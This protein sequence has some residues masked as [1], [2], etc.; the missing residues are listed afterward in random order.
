MQHTTRRWRRQLG[1]A[2]DAGLANEVCMRREGGLLQAQVPRRLVAKGRGHNVPFGKD[3]DLP[4][5][6][7][8]V[9]K[10]VQNVPI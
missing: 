7:L 4:V 6:R 1:S 5:E 10:S 8:G 3:S 2:W 9:V